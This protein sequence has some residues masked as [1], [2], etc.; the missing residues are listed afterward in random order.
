MKNSLFILLIFISTITLSQTYYFT[1]EK[2]TIIYDDDYGNQQLK[3]I[4]SN[5]DNYEFYFDL[6]DIDDLGIKQCFYIFK[7][8]SIISYAI[9]ESFIGYVELNGM[10]K[11]SKYYNSQYEYV[12]VYI[13]TDYSHIIIKKGEN[14]VGNGHFTEYN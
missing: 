11:L 4:S 12:L 8:G 3:E 7:N 13:K 5:S 14:P 1:N 6:Q 2:V 9:E 10:Y